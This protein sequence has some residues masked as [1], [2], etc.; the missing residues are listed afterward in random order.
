MALSASWDTIRW[1]LASRPRPTRS[2]LTGLR[3][4]LLM[5]SVAFLEVLYAV[6]GVLGGSLGQEGSGFRVRQGLWVA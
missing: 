3:G 6:G 2:I 1:A 5:A 4:S